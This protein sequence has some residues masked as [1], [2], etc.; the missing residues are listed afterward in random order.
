[1]FLLLIE[2][3]GRTISSSSVDRYM[4]IVT[5][6]C[7]FIYIY[8]ENKYMK[9]YRQCSKYFYFFYSPVPILLDSSTGRGTLL[10]FHARLNFWSKVPDQTLHGPRGAVRQSADRVQFY[11]FR[12]LP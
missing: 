1:M 8:T 9:S 12:K 11:L 6:A 3:S 2:P 7:K 10:F 5:I 4:G